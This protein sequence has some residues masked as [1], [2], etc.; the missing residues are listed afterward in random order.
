MRLVDPHNHSNYEIAAFH[1]RPAPKN[2]QAPKREKRAVKRP[3]LCA[4][5]KL[6][7][8]RALIREVWGGRRE[9][10]E[11]EVK[12]FSIVIII[13]HRDEKSGDFFSFFSSPALSSFFRNQITNNFF[14]PFFRLLLLCSVPNFII[15]I[16]TFSLSLSTVC[17][18]SPRPDN[19][20]ILWAS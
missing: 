20:Y 7:W 10:S 19:I 11:V 2:V 6:Y 4:Q 14:H 18:S 17:D 13:K 5:H 3:L 1:S 9:H 15:I 12:Q 16:T 8:K